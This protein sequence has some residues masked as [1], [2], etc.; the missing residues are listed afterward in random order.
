MSSRLNFVYQVA[1][2]TTFLYFPI[3]ATR[4]GDLNVFYLISGIIFGAQY[5]L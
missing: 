1:S 5:K 4:S 2:F 3:H